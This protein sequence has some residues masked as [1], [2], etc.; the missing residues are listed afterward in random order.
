MLPVISALAGLVAL[1]TAA[2]SLTSS[3]ENRPGQFPV[4]DG[5]VGGG[6]ATINQRSPFAAVDLEADEVPSDAALPVRYVENSGVCETDRSLYQASGYVDVT[7]T[8]HIFVREILTSLGPCSY[9]IG[10][11]SSG[12][13]KLGKTAGT[14]RSRVRSFIPGSHDYV[15]SRVP[16]FGSTVDRAVAP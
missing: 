8:Q 12:S 1:S 7:S 14:S 6:S 16:Q 10:A 13:L 4:V 3:L 15:G 9:R 11:C 5:V 2:P